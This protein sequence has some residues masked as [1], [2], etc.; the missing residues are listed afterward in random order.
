MLFLA[1]L[2][3]PLMA[4][5]QSHTQGPPTAAPP[6]TTTNP[7][8]AP[9]TSRTVPTAGKTTA[10]PHLTRTPA[11]PSPESVVEAYVAAINRG[12][13]PTAW[14]LVAPAVGGSYSGFAAG[15]RGTDHDVL[16]ITGIVGGTVHIALLAYQADGTVRH[17]A[18]TYTVTGDRITDSN[19]SVV[20]PA[21]TCGAPANPWGYTFCRGV[22]IT[23]P[24][25]AFCSVFTCIEN[26]TDGHGYAVECGDGRFS[27]SGGR[28]GA[29]SDHDGELRQLLAP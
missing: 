20:E 15:F 24:P 23:D 10:T 9:T 19:I 4:A 1:V 3:L 28:P 17:F 5:C 18:G 21:S 12:D 7:P 26:F 13:Y 6:A 27:L 22:V 25:A 16:T 8:S 14:R 29:C 11:A 2:V